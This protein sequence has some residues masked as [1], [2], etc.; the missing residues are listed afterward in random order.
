[1]V[2]VCRAGCKVTKPKGPKRQSHKSLGTS[3]QT[4]ALWTEAVPEGSPSPS[5]G[6]LHYGYFGVRPTVLGSLFE[7]FG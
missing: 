6:L 3:P 1:M 4:P 5:V 7:S 2:G